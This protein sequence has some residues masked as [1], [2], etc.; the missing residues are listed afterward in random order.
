M[1]N[2]A[3]ITACVAAACAMTA[4][5]ARGNDQQPGLPAFQ[6]AAAAARTAPPAD[7]PAPGGA[8]LTAAFALPPTP[9]APA[10]ETQ[11]RP[12]V[13][14]S[15]LHVAL[16]RDA[17]HLADA[18][19]WNAFAGTIG[20]EVVAADCTDRDAVELMLLGRV[21]MAVIARQLSPNDV[22]AGLRQT[23]LGVELFGLAVGP[24]STVRS[25]THQQVR[26][27]LTGQ[28][29]TWSQLGRHGGGIT[30]IVPGDPGFAA[31]AAKVLIPGDPFGSVC[32]RAA[33]EAFTDQRLQQDANAIAVVRVDAQPRAEGVRF[34]QIDWIAPSADAFEYGTYPFGAP[35]TLVT[36]GQPTGAAQQ[37]AA[38]ATTGA[39]RELLRSAVTLRY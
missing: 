30:A 9:A 8:S 15:K 27:V 26:Q 13:V 18:K 10:S 29:T 6:P 24:Q 35:L 3:R 39:G 28:V 16:G 31:R 19:L 33:S 14:A 34:V 1:G 17:A 36:S 2:Q 21:Q 4:F 5:V 25:L 38:F 12:E 11:R 20:D 37:F 22:Q 23:R 7:A 32:E